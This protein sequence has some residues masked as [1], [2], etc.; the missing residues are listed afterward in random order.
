VCRT[1]V[2]LLLTSLLLLGCASQ[3]AS[4]SGTY[5]SA[6][7]GQEH[8]T[9]HVN[10]TERG[11]VLGVAHSDVF[12]RDYALVGTITREGRISMGSGAV[13]TGARF[14]GVIGPD[15]KVH[16]SWRNQRAP[17]LY[18]GA[19][20][21]GLV[22]SP[23]DTRS[24]ATG[25]A[26]GPG[27]DR[28]AG[29]RAAPDSGHRMKVLRLDPAAD[30]MAVAIP[31]GW[32]EAQMPDPSGRS[33]VVEPVQ[34][35][36]MPMRMTFG[37]APKAGGV[38]LESLMQ[39]C[40][41]GACEACEDVVSSS[42]RHHD[43]HGQR[44]AERAVGCTRLKGGPDGVVMIWRFVAGDGAIY[45]SQHSWRVPPFTRAQGWPLSQREMKAGARRATFLVCGLAGHGPACP[46]DLQALVDKAIP[47]HRPPG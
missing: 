31:P 4:Y 24:L 46:P 17:S 10:L 2:A 22:A 15:G 19:F 1:W 23:V 29:M 36:G 28:P 44:Y 27:G 45:W 25:G 38:T 40:P 42:P 37:V 5:R 47:I 18:F 11:D 9:W 35:S 21:G 33:I 41:A 43:A 7:A 8:G 6:G 26:E 13:A 30:A 34:P 3:S 39:S 12:G 20:Q 14:Q 16:G 32:R